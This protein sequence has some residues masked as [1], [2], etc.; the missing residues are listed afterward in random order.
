MF[1]GGRNFLSFCVPVS[2]LYHLVI[3]YC[4]IPFAILSAHLQDPAYR[5]RL[6][7]QAAPDVQIHAVRQDPC[8]LEIGPA[9]LAPRLDGWNHLYN[10]CLNLLQLRAYRGG[11]PPSRTTV[12]NLPRAGKRKK[13]NGFV[14]LR[15]VRPIRGPLVEI[16]GSSKH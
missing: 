2:V 15:L 13:K 3:S 1:R 16:E 9:F 8:V 7:S 10:L 14:L 11:F 12:Q 4:P 5:V 6:A